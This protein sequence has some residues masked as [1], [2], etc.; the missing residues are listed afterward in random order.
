LTPNKLSNFFF[1]KVMTYT[2]N[3]VRN[4]RLLVWFFKLLP[5]TPHTNETIEYHV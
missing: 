4:N 2:K 3:I 5:F 1:K